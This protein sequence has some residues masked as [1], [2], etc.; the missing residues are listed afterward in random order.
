MEIPQLEH[1]Y[2]QWKPHDERWHIRYCKV[3]DWA[4]KGSHRLN[5]G[6][7]TVQPTESQLGIT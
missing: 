6:D 2:G 7:I 4:Y 1:D 3:C 5:D